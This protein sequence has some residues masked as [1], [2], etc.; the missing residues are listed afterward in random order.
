MRM[1][2]ICCPQTVY[3]VVDTPY[4]YQ[5][6]VLMHFIWKSVP[7]ILYRETNENVCYTIVSEGRP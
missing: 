2:D 5:K 7:L 4:F 1:A 6:A 3:Q